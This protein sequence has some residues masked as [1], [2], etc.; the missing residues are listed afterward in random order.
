MQT[1]Q[2]L[3]A[4]FI[5]SE[6]EPA[7]ATRAASVAAPSALPEAVPEARLLTLTIIIPAYN[8]GDAVGAVIAKARALRPDAEILVVDDGSKDNTSEAAIAA[9]ARV[10]RH[11][12]NKGNGAAV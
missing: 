4:P 5:A 10:V 12:Y 3:N 6:P 8:E 11:P 1:E 7:V 9:G 2:N